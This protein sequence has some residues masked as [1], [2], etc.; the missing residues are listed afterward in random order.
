MPSVSK[1]DLLG[2]AVRRGVLAKR[3]MPPL[4][5][6][7]HS[8]GSGPWS[9]SKA[10]PARF[11]TPFDAALW[12]YLFAMLDCPHVLICGETGRKARLCPDNL[13]ARHVGSAEHRRYRHRSESTYW[14]GLFPGR[15]SPIELVGG[16]LWAS[17]SVNN[18]SL[19][20]EVAPAREGPRRPWKD[21]VY[22][23]LAEQ[24]REW[25]S[26]YQIPV[27]AEYNLTHFEAH[28]VARTSEL[29]R[30]YDTVEGQFDKGRLL[31]LLAAGGS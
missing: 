19:G 18:V 21:L 29:G 28:P 25:V 22:P 1:T 31:R 8:T 16:R 27:D 13:G 6:I 9:R 14:K 20:V 3:R 4:C 15:E 5:I 17:H 2:L 7:Y 23:V 12:L 26:L 30:P 10:D 24:A 11:P